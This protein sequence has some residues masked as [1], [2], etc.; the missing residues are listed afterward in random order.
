MKEA[1]DAA[2]I[3]KHL[4]VQPLG[5][6]TPDAGKQGFIDLPEFPFGNYL[7]VKTVNSLVHQNDDLRHDIFLVEDPPKYS[8]THVRTYWEF[9]KSCCSLFSGSL[10]LK[11]SVREET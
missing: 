2:G 1:L 10:F 9:P 3:K 8:K 11:F 4:M 5:Y 7:V 6:L